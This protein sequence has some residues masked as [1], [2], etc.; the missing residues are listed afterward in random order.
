[1]YEC[2]NCKQKVIPF[3]K[4]FLIG[5]LLHYHCINCNA[6]LSSS[7]TVVFVIAAIGAIQLVSAI[8]FMEL[9][10]LRIIIH[11]LC[12]LCCLALLYYWIFHA[13]IVIANNSG[14]NPTQKN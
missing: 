10:L 1:M 9:V 3:S 5:P 14:G 8:C 2:P 13:P 6:A 4:K 11:L 7:Y 12:I